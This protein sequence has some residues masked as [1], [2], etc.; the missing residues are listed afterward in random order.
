MKVFGIFLFILFLAISV[1]IW[2]DLLMGYKLSTEWFHLLNPFMGMRGGEY[3][4]VGLL[5]LIIVGHQIFLIL[6]KKPNKQNESN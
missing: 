4:M 2:L 5:I 1:N 6:K 3:F